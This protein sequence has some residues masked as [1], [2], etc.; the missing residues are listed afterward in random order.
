MEERG[1]EGIIYLD[2]VDLNIFN[3]LYL[4]KMLCVSWKGKTK[5]KVYREKE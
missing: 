3:F 4:M 1:R 5:I 2:L